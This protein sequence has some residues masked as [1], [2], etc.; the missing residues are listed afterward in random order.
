MKYS[1]I[2]VCNRYNEGEGLQFLFF[3]G[4]QKNKKGTIS[5]SCFSQWYSCSFEVENIKYHSAEQYMMAEKARLFKDK[6]V[7]E[8]ILKAKEQ[9]EIKELG[10]KVKNFNLELWNSCKYEIVLQGNLAKFRENEDFK[11]FLLNSENKIIVEASPYDKVW[12]IGL[13]AD[14]EKIN[15]PNNWKGENLLG[16]ALMEVRDLIR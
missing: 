8:E 10:R 13:V 5:K 12:G 6:E 1:L 14:D 11:E 9:K 2:E 15:N 16:F 3:W 7:L 4:H